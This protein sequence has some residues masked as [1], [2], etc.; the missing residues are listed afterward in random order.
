VKRD[1][2]SIAALLTGLGLLAVVLAGCPPTPPVVVSPPSADGGIMPPTPV[3]TFGHCTTDALRTTGEGLLPAALTAVSTGNYVAELAALAAKFGQAEVS[4]A[5]DL[6]VG[7]LSKRAARSN[8]A[9]TA[10]Q[11]A[12]AQNYRLARP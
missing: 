5:V 8:D 10:L 12:R 2:F 6:L 1:A 3:A 4:C 9:L 11:L 7:E